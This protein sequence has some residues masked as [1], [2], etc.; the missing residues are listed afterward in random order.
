MMH[1]RV[2]LGLHRAATKDKDRPGKPSL[3]KVSNL[4]W[5]KVRQVKLQSISIVT[6]LHDLGK[7]FRDSQA[8]LCPQ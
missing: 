8:L 1:S 7:I 5:Q 6:E 4:M 3:P 2:T